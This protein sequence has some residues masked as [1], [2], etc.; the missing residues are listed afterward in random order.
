MMLASAFIHFLQ[1]H[2]ITN[3][4]KHHS[5]KLQFSFSFTRCLYWLMWC[6][7]LTWLG[8]WESSKLF[9]GTGTILDRTYPTDP[10]CFFYVYFCH[11]T[12]RR[13]ILWCLV[14][15]YYD[16]VPYGYLRY[17]IWLGGQLFLFLF[18][19][20]FAYIFLGVGG[21]WV[22]VLLR[23]SGTC[24]F[25]GNLVQNYK[26]F[27]QR[28]KQPDRFVSQSTKCPR[29]PIIFTENKSKKPYTTTAHDTLTA[30]DRPWDCS[31]VNP[32]AS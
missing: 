16:L 25:W 17:G 26:N 5:R 29:V 32:V 9:S 10:S 27:F 3:I 30:H 23:E 8:F 28:S 18:R 15:G 12:R 14:G 13:S 4:T 19:T 22:S 2:F 6:F 11:K 31:C 7:N 21:L 1:T 20:G 24:K